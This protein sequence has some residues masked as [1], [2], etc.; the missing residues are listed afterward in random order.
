M[1]V[2]LSILLL[3]CLGICSA[4]AD[5]GRDGFTLFL[6]RH[7][8]KEA[9]GSRDPKLTDAGEDRSK[10]LA[11]WFVDKDIRD[12]WSSDYI[13]TRDTARPLLSQLGLTLKIYDPRDQP[14][15]VR[16][17]LDRRLSALIV[18][19]SNTIPELARL[20]CQCT[21]ADMDES[22]HDRLI[23]ISFVNQ[24]ITTDILNQSELFSP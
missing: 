16:Q 17:L 7:A 13:R 22:E 8:E 4:N 5:E 20:L 18:G 23:I 6:V 24:S 2:L 11:G 19:H 1:R 3:S 14:E 10:N 15:L 12:I 21:I 9:D